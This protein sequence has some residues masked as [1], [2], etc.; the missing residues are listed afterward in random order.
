MDSRSK[1]F[2][3]TKSESPLLAPPSTRPFSAF[4]PSSFLSFL[5]RCLPS[6]YRGFLLSR[7]RIRE[8][9]CSF[10]PSSLSPRFAEEEDCET[11]LSYLHMEGNSRCACTEYTLDI[12]GIWLRSY[13]KKN[14]AAGRRAFLQLRRGT[15]RPTNHPSHR[16][17]RH[18]RYTTSLGAIG[19]RR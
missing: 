12:M 17:P 10:V 5:P 18:T 2:F 9:V 3:R 15:D 19:V 4:D 13:G 7:R 11:R 1:R 6:L 8:R 14:V 16:V